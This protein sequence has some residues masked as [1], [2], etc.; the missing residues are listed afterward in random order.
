M[1]P[2][3]TISKYADEL[4]KDV[5]VR[6]SPA[7]FIAHRHEYENAAFLRAIVRYLDDAFDQDLTPPS[8]KALAERTTN[9]NER[10]KKLE[11]EKLATRRVALW[12]ALAMIGPGCTEAN[13]NPLLEQAGLKRCIYNGDPFEVCRENIIAAAREAGLL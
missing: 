9:L 10:L 6:A 7:N 8:A 13:V 4:I 12:T 2:S 5:E 3:E 1:K 11:D